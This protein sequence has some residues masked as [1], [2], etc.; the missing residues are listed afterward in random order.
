ML[1]APAPVP[2]LRPDSAVEEVQSACDRIDGRTRPATLTRV[3]PERSAPHTPP[4]SMTAPNGRV[5]SASRLS[6][7]STPGSFK[8]RGTLNF[9]RAQKGAGTLPTAGVH[10]VW[11]ERGARVRMVCSTAGG[12]GHGVPARDRPGGES[13][14]V[15]GCGA[16]VRLVGSEYAEALAACQAF[17]STSGALAA[18]AYDPPLIAAPLAG[19]QR[20]TRTGRADRARGRTKSSPVRPTAPARTAPTDFRERHAVECGIARLKRHRAVATR[21]D[22]L[23]VRYEANCAGRCHRR[24][25]LTSTGRSTMQLSPILLCDCIA[26][27]GWPPNRQYYRL[28]LREPG[29]VDSAAPHDVITLLLQENTAAGEF[30]AE[31]TADEQQ[32]GRSLLASHPLPSLVTTRMDAPFDLNSLAVARIVGVLEVSE[33]PSPVQCRILARAAHVHAVVHDPDASSRSWQQDQGSRN[34][35]ESCGRPMRHPF[36]NSPWPWRRCCGPVFDFWDP[37]ARS[38]QGIAACT[39]GWGNVLSQ[40]DAFTRRVRSFATMLAERQG[41]RL[42]DWGAGVRQDDLPSLTRLPRT[43]TATVTP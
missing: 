1:T 34:R 18:H 31:A 26:G 8:A 37:T 33:E 2:D 22:K 10:R 4:L 39:Q 6:T 19:S 42:P 41:E 21:N 30:D 7:C 3:D 12:Q 32:E 9:L 13:G 5:R 35:P 36:G 20:I 40:F 24:V 43:S 17:A 38:G 15:R 29:V 25:A 11:R 23:G 28:L 14:Q 16:A 27:Y